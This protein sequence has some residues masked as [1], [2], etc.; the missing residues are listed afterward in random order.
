MNRINDFFQYFKWNFYYELC[1]IGLRQFEL[2]LI[3]QRFNFKRGTFLPKWKVFK[4][5]EHPFFFRVRC[6][7]TAKSLSECNFDMN[8]KE[9]ILPLLIECRK[10]MIICNFFYTKKLII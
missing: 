8:C 4:T 6:N 9:G 10:N 1:P 5:G 7:K 2:D 3:C